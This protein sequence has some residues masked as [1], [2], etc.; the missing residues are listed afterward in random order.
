MNDHGS[1][2]DVEETFQPS[3]ATVRD[4]REASRFE[5]LVDD[6]VAFLEYERGPGMITLVHTEVPQH[7]RGQ[8]LAGMLAKSA[9]EA[10]R[11]EGIRVI[12]KCPYVRAYIQR[13]HGQA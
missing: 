11:A 3:G 9:L 1:D 13:H 8:G 10:A 5:I 4:N 6:Q 2:D 12:A 7:L